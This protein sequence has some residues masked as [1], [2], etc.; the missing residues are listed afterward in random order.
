MAGG[1]PEI[2]WWDNK[3]HLFYRIADG[4]VVKHE[5]TDGVNWSPSVAQ[6]FE[7]SVGCC[8][9]VCDKNLYV[10]VRDPGG[11]QF[12]ITSVYR[13]RRAVS[14]AG[15]RTRLLATRRRSRPVRSLSRPSGF[16]A[17]R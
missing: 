9:V 4:K 11:I 3:L 5:S 17:A 6:G 2:V 7:S 10:F 12:A 15:A 13:G 16:G 1:A 8:S 14:P